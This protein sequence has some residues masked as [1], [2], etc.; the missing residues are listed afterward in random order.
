MKKRVRQEVM[1]WDNKQQKKNHKI[2]YEIF[3][4]LNL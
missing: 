2:F 4:F 3:K 1:K